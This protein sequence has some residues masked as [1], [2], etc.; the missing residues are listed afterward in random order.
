MPP[1]ESA[2]TLPDP[3][4]Y[5]TG[6]D[7]GGTKIEAVL[8][9]GSGCQLF[10]ERVAT[11]PGYRR[12]VDRIA[13]LVQRIDA[14]CGTQPPVGVGTPGAWVESSRTMKN[15]NSAWLNG[16]PLLDDLNAALGGRV[17]IANDANCMA[18]AEALDGAGRGARVVFGV[19][20]GTGVGGGIVVDGRLLAGANSVTGEWGH[21]PLP[22][23]RA[24]ERTLATEVDL[25]DRSCYCGRANCVETFLSG[26]GLATTHMELSGE[27]V[28]PEDIPL[29][30]PSIDLYT[31]MLARSLAQV[32]NIL[33]PDVIVLAGG[34][35]N[36]EGLAE[37]AEAR[38]AHYGFSHEGGTRVLRARHGDAS[39]VLGA[40]R[41]WPDKR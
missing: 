24:D 13:E 41:L 33:D 22:Y 20:L 40:C 11:P 18:L 32:V 9:D 3:D 25:G 23:L 34:L 31:T 14:S 19:I 10:R 38:M 35:S 6:L 8:L 39:G 36:L 16:K 2:K 27:Q 17:R 26:P 4:G 7:L 30:A 37:E 21:T 12:T 15:C 28:A 5:R 1:M 29:D